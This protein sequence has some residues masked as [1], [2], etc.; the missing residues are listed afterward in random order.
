MEESQ[1]IV[2]FYLLIIFSKAGIY[3]FMNFYSF[4]QELYNINM[5][6]DNSIIDH[7]QLRDSNNSY[8]TYG[9]FHEWKG[10]VEYICKKMENKTCV[11]SEEKELNGPEYIY[12]MSNKYLTGEKKTKY[13]DLLKNGKI[14]RLNESCEKNFKNCGKIDT[15]GQ[16]LCLSKEEECPIQDFKIS[17][18]EIKGYNNVEYQYNQIHEFISYSNKR[19][20][21]S[22]I[23]NI[24]LSSDTPCINNND[25]SWEKLEK[26]EKEETKYC[27]KEYKKQKKDIRYKLAG[28]ISYVNIYQSNL[29]TNAFN[30]MYSQLLGHS[31]GVYI[32]PF[33]GIDVDCYRNSKFDYDNNKKLQKTIDDLIMFSKS[34]LVILISI[35]LC[36]GIFKCKCGKDPILIILIFFNFIFLLTHYLIYKTLRKFNNNTFDCID[37]FTNFLYGRDQERIDLLIKLVFVL[38]ICHLIL[39]IHP[40]YLERKNIKNCF[41]KKDNENE[42]TD[43]NNDLSIEISEQQ[44]NENDIQ[45]ASIN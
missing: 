1:I 45:A 10:R 12:K 37:E 14:K 8:Y 24:T 28:T 20:D 29:P 16:K 43:N 2:F 32:R 31:L 11:E 33:I 27:K 42:N 26:K 36:G 7:F 9:P 3:I 34:Y 41:K 4:A 38:I 30:S 17:N 6:L 39:I 21:L 18:K 40:L 22:I 13:I 44:K 15:L 35:F 23:G 5:S 19:T 25:Q